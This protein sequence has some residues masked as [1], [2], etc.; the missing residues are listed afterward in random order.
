MGGAEVP[1]APLR[2]AEG[3]APAR[4]APA[5]R[6]LHRTC[7]GF[8]AKRCVSTCE[9]IVG[10]KNA[11]FHSTLGSK[12]ARNC[13]LQAGAQLR[14]GSRR[15]RAPACR[16]R[17]AGAPERRC[18]AAPEP[19]RALPWSAGGIPGALGRTKPA[20]PLHL[21]A[22]FAAKRCIS[23]SATSI[24]AQNAAFRNT[25]GSRLHAGGA[26]T[27]AQERV[28]RKMS[29]SARPLGAPSAPGRLIGLWP[30]DRR[31]ARRTVVAPTPR[32]GHCADAADTRCD[33]ADA[34]SRWRRC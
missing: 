24:A 18:A 3:A 32:P 28:V 2:G 7:A 19:P 17:Y 13:G 9:T 31:L 29:A 5:D 34:R 22:G 14:A 27:D 25:L 11:A 26:S 4:G 8:A 16:A 15:A 12:P 1:G 30:V 21:C 23:A 10:K 6:Q 33:A 20:A